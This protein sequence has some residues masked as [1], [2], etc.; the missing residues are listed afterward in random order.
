MRKPLICLSVILAMLLSI[1]LL[2]ILGPILISAALEIMARR[3]KAK[4]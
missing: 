4:I 3:A 2:G 1:A